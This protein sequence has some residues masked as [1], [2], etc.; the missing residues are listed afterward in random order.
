MGELDHS[1]PFSR[2]FRTELEAPSPYESHSGLAKAGF[3]AFQTL[4]VSALSG[5][6]STPG[7]LDVPMKTADGR[8][9]LKRQ[10]DAGVMGA[11]EMFR[12]FLDIAHSGTQTAWATVHNLTCL[13]YTIL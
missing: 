7:A 5:P 2:F 3:Q 8:Q 4:L 9:E 10:V 11:T 1:A 13:L 6:V 12:G